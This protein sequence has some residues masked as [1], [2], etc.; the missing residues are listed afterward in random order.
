MP[1]PANPTPSE[2]AEI[3]FLRTRIS[4][5]HK[6]RH[7]LKQSLEKLITRQTSD[8]SDL[9]TLLF[10]INLL[11]QRIRLIQVGIALRRKWSRRMQKNSFT[12]NVH[13]S[14]LNLRDTY[15]TSGS[16]TFFLLSY[17]ST[18]KQSTQW[19][20]CLHKC[21]CQA[22]GNQ[23]NTGQEVGGGRH[24]RWAE[25]LTYYL[26]LCNVFSSALISLIPL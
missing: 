3:T 2:L 14:F 11:Q 18:F 25:I 19:T 13:I 24:L 6:I 22:R 17:S 7:S 20:I 9:S 15:F 8:S 1:P 23:G 4:S 21:S 16:S 5:T 10:Q 26:N 12:S